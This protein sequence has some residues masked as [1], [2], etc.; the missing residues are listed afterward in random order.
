MV[1]QGYLMIHA[2]KQSQRLTFHF[3]TRPV[4][5]ELSL[6]YQRLPENFEELTVKP[7]STQQSNMY[8]LTTVVKSGRQS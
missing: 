2:T 4:F 6:N 7:M 5:I 1:R 3:F 8:F